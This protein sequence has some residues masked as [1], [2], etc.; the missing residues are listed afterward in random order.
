[1]IR[2]LLLFLFVLAAL[3]G[4]GGG[5][6]TASIPSGD[7][8]GTAAS[9]PIPEEPPAKPGKPTAATR[10][11]AAGIPEATSKRPRIKRPKGDP[12]EQLVIH[13][14]VEGTGPEA[15]EG[16]T[17]T[18][19]YAGA[20]WSQGK[21]FDASWGKDPFQ[22]SLGQGS[23]IEGWELGIPGMRRGGRRVLVI[24]GDLAYG[25]EGSPPDIGPNETLIFVVDARKIG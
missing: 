12:P 20:T 15:K 8:T 11:V 5:D 17:V 3:A 21:E 6:Q 10:A 2:R 14:I 25:A 4:C 1:M 19:D 7:E 16:D 18:V 22:V 23:V 13:D 9:A 24:P